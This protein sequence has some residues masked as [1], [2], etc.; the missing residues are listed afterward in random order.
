MVAVA[1]GP[2]VYIWSSAV[3]QAG[4][5][6]F[7]PLAPLAVIIPGAQLSLLYAFLVF[8]IWSNRFVGSARTEGAYVFSVTMLNGSASLV[9]L[10]DSLAI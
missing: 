9:W 7:W 6:A 4:L 3:V 10:F 8:A 1:F 5:D 2:W